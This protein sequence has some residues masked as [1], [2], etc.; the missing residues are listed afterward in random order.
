MS[1]KFYCHGNSLHALRCF[2][3]FQLFPA[4]PPKTMEKNLS[5]LILLPTEL[6]FNKHNNINLRITTQSLNASKMFISESF[7][8]I[9][10]A[11]SGQCKASLSVMALLWAILMVGAL[12]SLSGV[13]RDSS[14][15]TSCPVALSI[16][17]LCGAFC[18]YIY[19]YT[20]GLVLHGFTM[21]WPLLNITLSKH[22]KIEH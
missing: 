16:Y 6:G 9:K 18:I 12:G 5:N 19:I 4:G 20:Y 14:K 7:G 15:L 11:S 2:H 22:P 10:A 1:W 21:W 3:M 13:L 8:G 17:T